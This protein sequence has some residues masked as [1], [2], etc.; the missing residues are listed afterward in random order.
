MNLNK[1]R[2]MLLRKR[3]RRRKERRSMKQLNSKNIEP[4]KKLLNKKQKLRIKTRAK[5]KNN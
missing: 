4:L 5:L 1:P 2:R 3:R